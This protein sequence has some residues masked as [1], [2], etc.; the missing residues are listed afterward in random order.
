MSAISFIQFSRLTNWSVKYLKG[1]A[2]NY[3]PD[4]NLVRIGDFLTRSKT[5]VNVEDDVEYK[6][7]T[8]RLY[9][10]GV[11][12]RDTEKGSNIGTKRQFLVKEG[13]FLLSK[14]DARN[15]AFGIATEEVDNAIIT[16]DFF[17]YDID[18]SVIDPT[19]MVLIS[20]TKQF[21]TFAQ[22]AS[23]GTTGRQRIQED[24][25]LNMEIPLPSLKDQEKMVNQYQDNINKAEQIDIDIANKQRQVAKLLF[26]NKPEKETTNKLLEFSSFKSLRNWSVKTLLH[27]GFSFNPD[28]DLV[29]I[30]DFL[31]R[32][33]TLID[34]QDDVEYKRVTIKM[35]N[36]GVFLRDQQI[37]SKIGTK[38]QY[39]INEGQFLLSKIDARNG[40]FG[41]VTEEV[42]NAIITGNFWTFD[43][44]TSVID[45][46]FLS[47]ITANDQFIQ[48]CAN[49]SNGTTGRH[50]L[51]EDDFLNVQIPLPSLEEQEKILKGFPDRAEKAKLIEAAIQGF[52][53][54]IFIKS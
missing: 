42:D 21:Q 24:E 11:C 2:F 29:R 31:T 45:P 13:Q 51:Q 5:V 12:Q 41:V 19:F 27:E 26:S 48:F 54:A 14:I 35:N 32:N 53:D 3:N 34:V 30:G 52:E 46:T 7:V 17:A 37:G 1:F 10:K 50:Y 9:N 18:T 22:A 25:F 43:V 8:I 39:V 15:G 49:A 6:R 4:F 33:K 23:K 44:D 28:F 38:K 47:L 16:A 20:T 36:G 40:A